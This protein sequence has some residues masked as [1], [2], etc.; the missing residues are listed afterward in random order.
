MNVCHLLIQP[1][2][3]RNPINVMLCYL[4]VDGSSHW[5]KTVYSDLIADDDKLAP[6][7]TKMYKKQ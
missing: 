6:L 7:K 4:G 3:C 1:F 2:G 5:K